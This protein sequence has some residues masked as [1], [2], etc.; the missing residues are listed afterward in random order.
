MTTRGK[1][2]LAATLWAS[3]ALAGCVSTPDDAPAWYEQRAA[4]RGGR[5]PSLHDV[6]RTSIANTDPN[7]WAAVEAD[8]IAAGVAMKANPRSEPSGPTAPDAFI[9]E[10]RGEL[11]E[12]R[13]SHEP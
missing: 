10:A 6:P 4:E 7:H 8:V 13:A 11:D 9:A 12:A 2:I 1:V 3:T 5:Y